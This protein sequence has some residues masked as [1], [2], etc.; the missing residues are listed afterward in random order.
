MDANG[1]L[2]HREDQAMNQQDEDTVPI[3]LA[4]SL[5]NLLKRDS[6][7]LKEST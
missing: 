2:A 6:I 7:L 5:S 4:A 1:I 3:V